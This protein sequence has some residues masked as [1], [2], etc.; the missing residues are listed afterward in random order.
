MSEILEKLSVIQKLSEELKEN[1]KQLKSL[2]KK[3]K[4]E[5]FTTLLAIEDLNGYQNVIKPLN[6]A[7][8]TAK[9]RIRKLFPSE[10]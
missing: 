4:E 2:A 1:L 9:A 10:A 6:E 7:K 8:E 3:A 5:D